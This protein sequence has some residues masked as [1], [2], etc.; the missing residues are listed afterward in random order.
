MGGVRA[1]ISAVM[2]KSAVKPVAF[3][4]MCFDKRLQPIYQKVVKPVLEDYGFECRR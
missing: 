3:V 2:A 1:V 4:A